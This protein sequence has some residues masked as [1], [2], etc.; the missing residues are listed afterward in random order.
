VSVTSYL[1]SNA[2]HHEAG[3]THSRLNQ[4]VNNQSGSRSVNNPSSSSKRSRPNNNSNAN[5]TL[6]SVMEGAYDRSNHTNGA[7]SANN[8]NANG[9]RR[10]MFNAPPAPSTSHPSLMYSSGSTLNASSSMHYERAVSHSQ[11]IA[12]GTDWP[13]PTQ[14]EGPGMPVAR[15]LVFSQPAQQSHA[16][17][18]AAVAAVEATSTTADAEMEGED[19]LDN[20]RYC[21]C[22]GVSYGEMIACDDNNCEQEWVMCFFALS[23][24]FSVD[25]GRFWR[26]QFH[27]G[28]LDLTAPPSG[29]WFCEA[30]KARKNAKRSGRGGK[31]KSNNARS[32]GRAVANG[33]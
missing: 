9:T 15:P 32:G 19:D 23:V 22:N 5:L 18:A 4:V 7:S 27:L 13:A 17:A 31:R 2:V 29:R 33:S 12:S 20:R 6:S 24:T 10:D 11:S 3:T 16:A 25:R 26:P 8:A 14:L 28:C 21:V 1:P 30:C